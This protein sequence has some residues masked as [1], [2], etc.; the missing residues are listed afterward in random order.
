MDITS[1]MMCEKCEESELDRGMR[2]Y[3]FHAF[4]L[5]ALS[6][7]LLAGGIPFEYGE[8]LLGA[9]G[10]AALSPFYNWTADKL[11]SV[12]ESAAEYIRQF[13]F[14]VGTIYI[15]GFVLIGLP[16]LIL[17]L[18]LGQNRWDFIVS[19][20]F[21]SILLFYLVEYLRDSY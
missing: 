13:R 16:W 19:I 6:I 1:V 12:S 2:R 9:L 5:M 7:V 14:A 15:V 20:I 3:P 18:F 11:Y 4:T 17:A 8:I 21:C 10:G